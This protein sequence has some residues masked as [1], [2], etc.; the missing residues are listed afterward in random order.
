MPSSVA[1]HR[2]RSESAAQMARLAQPPGGLRLRSASIDA[3][4]AGG[5]PSSLRSPPGPIRVSSGLPARSAV[6]GSTPAKVRAQGATVAPYRYVWSAKTASRITSVVAYPRGRLFRRPIRMGLGPEP[7][8]KPDVD[9]VPDPA[10]SAAAGPRFVGSVASR[11]RAQR[12]TARPSPTRSYRPC[13][14]QPSQRAQDRSNRIVSVLAFDARNLLLSVGE[15]EHPPNSG[16]VPTAKCCGRRRHR[17]D[18]QRARVL[19]GVKA[20]RCAPPPLRGADGLDAGSAHARPD[21]LLPTMPTCA[22]PTCCGR[23]FAQNDALSQRPLTFVQ[24]GSD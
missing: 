16:L 21:W 24:E 1:R 3:I 18:Q 4:D 5:M 10:V 12:S 15:R 22:P 9:P 23:R 8:S 19:T 17:Q 7:A 2:A 13:G 20:R 14:S 11:C 6:L